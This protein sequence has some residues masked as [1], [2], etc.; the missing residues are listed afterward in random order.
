MLKHAD[1]AHHARLETLNRR[2]FLLPDL[3]ISSHHSETDH[4]RVEV[5]LNIRREHI[6]PRLRSPTCPQLRLLINHPPVLHR[7]L[8]LW[9]VL[10][11]H[12]N[13][14]SV[15][16]RAPPVRD[17]RRAKHDRASANAEHRLNLG[18]SRADERNLRRA[19]LVHRRR[20]R[21]P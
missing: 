11:E 3:K 18:V 4:S 21:D 15:P 2:I 17:P 12:L 20:A 5:L 6:N 13:N 8:H 14:A 9:E 10:L 1:L 7:P 16:R 19:R